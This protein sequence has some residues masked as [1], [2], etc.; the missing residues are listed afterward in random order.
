MRVLVA[1]C[2]GLIGS[3][4]SEALMIRGDT[5]VGLDNML[6]GRQANLDALTGPRFVYIDG[7]ACSAGALKEAGTVDAV[8]HLASPASPADFTTRALEILRAGS[9][10]TFATIEYALQNRARYLFASTSEVY[11][12]PAVHPQPEDYW[13]HVSSTGPRACYDESKRFSEAAITTYARLHDL[14]AG[15]V[16]IFN[17]YGPRMRIDDGRVISNFIVQALLGE[18]L[19]IY[20]DGLQT[21]SYCHVDDLVG[22]LLC[23]LDSAELGPINMGNPR[24]FTVLDLAQSVLELTHSNSQISF[25]SL[26]GDDPTHRRPDITMAR[27]LF[28]WEPAIGLTDGLESVIEYFRSELV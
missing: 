23:L 26:P 3:H 28:G 25:E 17:T 24:E 15:I 13:G 14:D 9:L 6:T 11:G 10:A 16:R 8:V 21:R 19:T 2:A 20:G 12:E 1:G 5:V 7:D 27:R 4:L 18:P 22:G